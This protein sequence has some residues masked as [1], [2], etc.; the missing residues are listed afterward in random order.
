MS[1]QT[2]TRRKAATAMNLDSTDRA[3]A[4]AG[5]LLDPKRSKP[6]VE[7]TAAAGQSGPYINVEDIIHAVSELADVYAVPTRSITFA[8][9]A[10]WYRSVGDEGVVR[11]TRCVACVVHLQGCCTL[12]TW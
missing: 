2:V 9:S 12:T 1:A 6:V 8:K 10:R 3:L 11:W 5:H 7:V 4:L